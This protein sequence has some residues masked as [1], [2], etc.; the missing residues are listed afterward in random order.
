MGA[1]SSQ[2][3]SNWRNTEVALFIML[4]LTYAIIMY[5]FISLRGKIKELTKRLDDSEGRRLEKKKKT[6]FKKFKAPILPSPQIHSFTYGE[7]YL[8][9]P[10]LKTDTYSAQ[11]QLLLNSVALKATT[12]QSS[13]ITR[14]ISPS[15]FDQKSIPTVM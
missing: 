14:P 10:M 11:S 7:D 9:K 3:S 12:T 5:I 15:K 1:V 4:V 2:P 8:Q 6:Y 13:P